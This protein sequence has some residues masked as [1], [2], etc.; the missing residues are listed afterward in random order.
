MSEMTLGMVRRTC[1]RDSGEILG[2][3]QFV[4]RYS[5]A[6]Q[7]GVNARSPESRRWRNGTCLQMPDQGTERRAA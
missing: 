1:G 5:A 7:S 3:A 2:Y 4:G 6:V